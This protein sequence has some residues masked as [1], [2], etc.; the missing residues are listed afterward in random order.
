[1]FWEDTRLYVRVYVRTSACVALHLST[2]CRVSSQNSCFTLTRTLIRQFTNGQ[3]D[4]NTR[5]SQCAC[6]PFSNQKG[7]TKHT[8]VFYGPKG[9]RKYCTYQNGTYHLVRS[10][11]CTRVRTMVLQ[12]R[13]RV[14]TNITLS[15]KRLEIQALR[16]N[17]KTSGRCQHR[18]SRIRVLPCLLTLTS[19]RLWS[20]PSCGCS[21][22]GS[23]VAEVPLTRPSTVAS[24]SRMLSCLFVTRFHRRLQSTTIPHSAFLVVLQLSFCRLSFLLLC[25]AIPADEGGKVASG[26]LLCTYCHVMSQRTRVPWYVL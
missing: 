1:V 17:G 9:P 2:G 10:C 5:G 4:Q 18:T 20:A 14:R 22:L 11:V 15:K 16:C 3:L 24:L 25:I 21:T 23:T 7:V 19:P 12:Y 26:L 13:T 6:V 8:Y